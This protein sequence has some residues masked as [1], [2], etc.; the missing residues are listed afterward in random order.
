MHVR[1]ATADDAASIAAVDVASWQAAYRGLMPDQYLSALSSEQREV[2]WQ[3]RL[4]GGDAQRGRRTY[5]ADEGEIAGFVR[6][7]PDPDDPSGGFVFL[8]YV[9]PSYWRTG[10]GTALM[11][12]ADA[13]FRDMG[14]GSATLGVLEANDRARR[15]YERLGWHTDGSRQMDTYGGR[16]LAVLRYTRSL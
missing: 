3:R 1:P 13:A 10:V 6:L 16:D 12:A 7:G 5:V 2:D 4:L 14:L 9:L 15:F 8:L 11:A